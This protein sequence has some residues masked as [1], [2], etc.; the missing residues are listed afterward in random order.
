[1][2]QK[3]AGETGSIQKCEKS[4]GRGILGV[5]KERHEQNGILEREKKNTMPQMSHCLVPKSF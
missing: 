2:K 3:F 1:M 5:C 4:M